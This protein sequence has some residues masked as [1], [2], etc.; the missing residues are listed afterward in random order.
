MNAVI[1]QRYAEIGLQQETIELLDTPLQAK[2]L[3]VGFTLVVFNGCAQWIN[4]QH[5][6]DLFL[7]GTSVPL[8]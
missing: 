6:T 5:V 1:R 4:P 8:E 3:D 7:Y 2:L